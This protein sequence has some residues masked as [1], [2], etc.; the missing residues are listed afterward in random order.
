M[1][2]ED[3]ALSRTAPHSNIVASITAGNPNTPAVLAVFGAFVTIL[4]LYFAIAEA[5]VAIKHDM[6]EA[7]AWGQEFQLGYNQHP[8]FWAWICGL[9]FLIFPRTEWAF[10][11]LSSLNAGIGLWGAWL[12]I[13]DFAEGRK[14]MAAWLLLLLTPLYTFYAFKYDANIIF[15]SIWPWALHYFM[16][17]MQSRTFGHAIAFGIMIGIALISKYYALILIATCFLAAL[18]HPSR[19]SYFASASPY[20]ST[21]VAAV[22]CVPHVWWLLTHRAPPVRYL[23]SVTGWPWPYIVAHAKDALFDSLGMNLGVVIVVGLVAWTSRRAGLAAFGAPARSPAF[24]MLATLTLTPLVLTVASALALRTTIKS[25]MVIGTYP[26]LP[27]LV[28]EGIGVR[29]IDRLYRI[30]ARLAV[31]LMLGTLA[32]SPAIAWYRTYLSRIAMD[33]TPFQEIALAATNL[34]HD[35]TSLPLAYVAGTDWYE[36]ATAFYS[37]DRPHVFVEFDYSRNL[38]V[39]PEDIAKHG[40]LAICVSNDSVC[41][42]RT[43]QFATPESTRTELAV[44]HRFWGHVA[45]PI[46]FIVTVIPPRA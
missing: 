41:L 33:A 34:W 24:R 3:Q 17:S 39:T 40:L 18:Q 26:L 13:G 44:A 16:K 19:R 15:L 8:P 36:N 35:R 9:W 29:D 23:E 38:W 7:Y 42:A 31:G 46:H 12:L 45:N 10:G 20:I 28:I 6:A 4:A 14:R 30:S 5:P 22:V 1:I 25:E 32:L 37:P 11:L 27:L 43:A 2:V 21:I